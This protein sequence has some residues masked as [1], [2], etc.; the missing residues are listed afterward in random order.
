MVICGIFSLSNFN[1][2]RWIFTLSLG[3]I[4]ADKNLL[5]RFK[6]FKIVKRNKYIDYIIKTVVYTT[7]LVLCVYLRTY[8]D[9]TVSYLRDGLIPAVVIIW[10]YTILFEIK[11]I[12]KILEFFGKYSM[13]IFLSHTLLRGYLLKD[14]IYSQRYSLVIFAVL[15]IFSLVFAIVID[16]LKKLTRYNKF[17]DFVT[18]K[19]TGKAS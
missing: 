10:C 19:I 6:S 2:V 8:A 9:W 14:F 15:L 5:A 16:L 13:N 3:M 7:V 18:G 17:T 12:F 1:M 11:F 4:C